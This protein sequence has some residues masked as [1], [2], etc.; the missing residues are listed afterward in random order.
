MVS[1]AGDGATAAISAIKYVDELK[2]EE[3]AE[4]KAT[5]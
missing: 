3:A 4:E 5:V 2:A 1:S